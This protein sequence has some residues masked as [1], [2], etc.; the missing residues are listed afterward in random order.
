M[1]MNFEVTI[2]P[3]EKRYAVLT[4]GMIN[5]PF[6]KSDRCP[7]KAYVVATEEAIDQYHAYRSASTKYQ[8][9]P[10]S[11]IPVL[12]SPF[13]CRRHLQGVRNLPEDPKTARRF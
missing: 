12:T 9:E 6:M 7:N 1:T 11:K 5:K 3:D 2:I 8:R 4:C 13:L 10:E